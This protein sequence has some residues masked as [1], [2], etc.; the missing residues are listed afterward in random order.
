MIFIYPCLCFIFNFSNTEMIK[1]KVDEIRMH[2]KF[3]G[4]F[5]DVL[6]REYQYKYEAVNIIATALQ[7]CVNCISNLQKL[8]DV[9]TAGNAPLDPKDFNV[10]D[11]MRILVQLVIRWLNSCSS[12]SLARESYYSNALHV[13]EQEIQVC[14]FAAMINLMIAP[15]Q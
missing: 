9:E 10:D 6:C 1:S 11:K 13:E 12:S 14:Q 5:L 15:G 4:Q 7:M 2:H 8:T 3:A